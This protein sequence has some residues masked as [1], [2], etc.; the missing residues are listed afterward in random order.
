MMLAVNMLAVKYVYLDLEIWLLIQFDKL[1]LIVGKKSD[2]TT[3]FYAQE[4]V[5]LS[6][7]SC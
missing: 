1:L 4:T 5:V 6:V 3:E 2:L 7:A